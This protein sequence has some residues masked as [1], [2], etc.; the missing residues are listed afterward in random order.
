MVYPSE[1]INCCTVQLV[2]KYISLLPPI[3]PK[4]KKFNF[5][6]HS[7]EHTN[8]RQWY[9]EQVVGCHTLTLVVKELLKS[10][11]LDGHFTNHSLCRTGTTQ[12]FQAGVDKKVIREYTGHRSD[13]INKYQITSGAQKEKVSSIL[14][15]ENSKKNEGNKEE[16]DVKEIAKVDIM[17]NHSQVQKQTCKVLSPMLM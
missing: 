16:V 10:A 11:K 2:D 7:L 8:P 5:Y 13:A 9:E 6:L 12:L 3:T 1:N 14:Y 15:G 17:V 4:T